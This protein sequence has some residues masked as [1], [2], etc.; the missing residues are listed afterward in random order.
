MN[1]IESNWI[2]LNSYCPLID[3]PGHAPTSIMFG[4]ESNLEN[5]SNNKLLSFCCTLSREHRPWQLV[6]WPRRETW[7][8]PAS[9][10]ITKDEYVVRRAYHLAREACRER[11]CVQFSRHHISICASSMIWALHLKIQPY[12]FHRRQREQQCFGFVTNS[13]FPQS[14]D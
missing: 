9:A 7:L 14:D 4:L 10:L 8:T 5:R 11:C 1:E 3:V 12:R 13:G 2:E 6:F